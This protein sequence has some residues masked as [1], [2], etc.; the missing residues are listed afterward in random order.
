SVQN[1]QSNMVYVVS[2]GPG[3]PEW[4]S[5]SWIDFV[6]QERCYFHPFGKSGGPKEP[7]NYIG[8]RYKGRL[9]S[10]HHI[11]SWKVVDSLAGVPG[12][13]PRRGPEGP[14]LLYD[15]GPPIVPSSLPPTGDRI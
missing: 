14:F 11:E 12:V 10:I 7:P 4:S 1:Q 6:E 3:T 2:L 9:Q 13:D 8:V 15:L 5:T